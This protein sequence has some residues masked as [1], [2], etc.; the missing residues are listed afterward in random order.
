MIKVLTFLAI[1]LLVIVTALIIGHLS[2][3]SQRKR[4]VQNLF[5]SSGK[6]TGIFLKEQIADLPEPVQRYFNYSL[7]EG[8]SFISYARLKHSGQFR[9]K[10]DQKWTSITGVEYFTTQNPGL[11]WFGKVPFISATDKYVNGKGNLKV[12]FLSTIKFID[13]KGETTDQGEF[14][15]WLSEAV[16]YPTALLPSENMKWEAIDDNSAKIIYSDDRISA[17]GIFHFNE[18]GQISRFEAMRYMDESRLEHWT[19]NCSDYKQVNGMHLPFF[20]EVIWNLD[21][22]DFCYAKFRVD[23]IEYGRPELFE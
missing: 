2:E 8:Q 14:L 11:V 3:R 6:V 16:W 5:N 12:K 19:I 22:G 9:Q 7:Q 23:T 18:I 15:R 21:A 10:P 1:A 13:A 4:E 17:E 20:A